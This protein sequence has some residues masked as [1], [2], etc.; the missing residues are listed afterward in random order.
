MLGVFDFGPL[1]VGRTEGSEEPCLFV[2][3]PDEVSAPAHSDPIEFESLNFELGGENFMLEA[4]A[5]VRFGC[6]V[7]VLPWV[8][9]MKVGVGLETFGAESCGA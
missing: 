5:N 4:G 9:C 8:G 7:P 6:E 3:G 2:R 1:A